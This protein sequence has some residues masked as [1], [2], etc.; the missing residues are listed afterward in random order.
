MT[1]TANFPGL[2]Q[3]IIDGFR[4]RRGDELSFLLDAP[5]DELQKSAGKLQQHFCGKHIDLCTIINGRSGR[6]SEDCRYCAQSARHHTDCKEYGFLSA[7]ELIANAK[8]NE[9]AG[10][11]RIAIV[12]SG[13]ALQGDDFDK[14]I[15]A[16]ERMRDELSIGLC[17]SHGIIG[18]EE[19]SRLRRAGVTSYHHNI[20]TSRRYFPQ[21]CTTH[22]YDDRIRTIKL[23]QSEG[24][25]VCSG[26]IIGMGE[27]W[28]DRL[29]MAISLAELG[30]Q[31]IPI[32]ALMPIPGTPLEGMERISPEDILR[33]IAIFRFLNPTANIRLAAGRKLLPENGATAFLSGA[34]AS[35]TGNMLTTSGTTMKE[36]I[37]MLARLGLTN[38]ED[39]SQADNSGVC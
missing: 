2:V 32:N 20:E 38:K 8:A 10:A 4:L 30:I 16:Y 33:T 19:F 9:A 29:D 28:E 24:L 7:D 18:A 11:N 14:A 25:N 27:T 34:S 3:E 39:K 35:I 36:D 21:I 26:G 1:A 22:T 15:A 17:A 31:S 37:D 6:C 12:T 13:R 23:A 5:L